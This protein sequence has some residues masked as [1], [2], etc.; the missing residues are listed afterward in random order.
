MT[1]EQ[2]VIYIVGGLAVIVVGFVIS[3]PSVPNFW[4]WL[5]LP[6]IAVVGGIIRLLR[7]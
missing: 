2:A 7:S 5:A 1:R 4:I 6:G 3:G